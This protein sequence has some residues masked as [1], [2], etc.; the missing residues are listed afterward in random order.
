M[1]KANWTKVNS[2]LANMAVESGVD[3]NALY[4]QC[5]MLS[6]RSIGRLGPGFDN[7]DL[8]AWVDKFYPDCFDAKGKNTKFTLDK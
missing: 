6:F 5:V 8:I 4:S 1:T 3:K 7:K 2:Y